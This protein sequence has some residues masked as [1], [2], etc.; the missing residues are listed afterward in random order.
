MSGH[1]QEQAMPLLSF[2]FLLAFQ[3]D[4]L[5]E[6]GPSILRVKCEGFRVAM[7]VPAISTW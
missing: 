4:S 2:S 3:M 1:P 6:A 7:V 5:S